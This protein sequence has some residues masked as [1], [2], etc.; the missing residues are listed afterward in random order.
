MGLTGTLVGLLFSTD[1]NRRNGSDAVKTLRLTSL[2]SVKVGGTILLEG[3]L[4]AT[5]AMMVRNKRM[6]MNSRKFWMMQLLTIGAMI[7]MITI[8]VK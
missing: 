1:M 5:V 2:S 7:Q 4:I 3:K 8:V 6:R